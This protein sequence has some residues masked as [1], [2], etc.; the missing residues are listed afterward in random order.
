[1]TF[2]KNDWGGPGLATIVL[3]CGESRRFQNFGYET[4]KQ[5]IQFE[6][7]HAMGSPRY[8]ENFMCEN[9]LAGLSTPTI[10]TTVG[11]EKHHEYL[12]RVANN[13]LMV[14]SSRGQAQ[15]ALHKFD[16]LDTLECYTDA[17]IVNCD[18][19]FAPGV[20]DRLVER[21]R[22]ANCIAVLTFETLESEETR[23]SFV[24]DHPFFTTTGE[25]QHVSSCTRAIAGA[26][27]VPRR[28]FK[29]FR[30]SLYATTVNPSGHEPYISHALRGVAGK[31]LSVGM[32]R[33]EFYD[34]GTP[35]SFKEFIR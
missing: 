6:I 28:L 23:W 33:A 13:T 21:G 3:A 30:D 10:V 34:W 15:T 9:V 25:K 29:E 32:Y 20:L 24:D 27:Y 31:K 19:G 16:A 18:N 22:G 17:L 14:P 4:P 8:L 35:E 2:W 26:Y 1:M 5:Y 7:D 12:L 11:L